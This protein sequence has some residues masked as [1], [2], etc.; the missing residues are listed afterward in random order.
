M[1]YGPRG[2]KKSK[3]TAAQIKPLAKGR[4]GCLP[5]DRLTVFGQELS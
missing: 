5:T 2:G 4:G 1:Q 3:L